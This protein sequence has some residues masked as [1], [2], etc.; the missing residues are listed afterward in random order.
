MGVHHELLVC[1]QVKQTA[2]GIIRASSKGM[3][4]GKELGMER[5]KESHIRGWDG[6]E[7]EIGYISELLFQKDI[8]SFHLKC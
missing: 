3:T 6:V 4:I 8:F 7:G 5:R 2:G 1:S